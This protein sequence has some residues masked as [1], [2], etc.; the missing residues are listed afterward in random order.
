MMRSLPWP[1]TGAVLPFASSLLKGLAIS[2][3][4]TVCFS[5]VLSGLSKSTNL[6][7]PTSPPNVRPIQLATVE[8]NTRSETKAVPVTSGRPAVTSV[9]KTTLESSAHQRPTLVT[10][11][12]TTPAHG[13]VADIGVMHKGKSARRGVEFGYGLVVPLID[14]RPAAQRITS[15]RSLDASF[16]QFAT[17]ADTTISELAP[18][19]KSMPQ[20]IDTLRQRIASVIN[21][22]R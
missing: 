17:S 22:L 8:P 12:R 9:A 6:P 21:V 5:L 13:A 10:A 16:W 15:N 20:T 3:A 2:A 11:E 18:R 1:K 14:T 7:P 4:T 19:R